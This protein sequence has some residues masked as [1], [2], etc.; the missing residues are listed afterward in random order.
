MTLH[1]LL[2]LLQDTPSLKATRSASHLPSTTACMTP[3]WRG[4]SSTPT[5]TP[6]TTFLQGRSLLMYHLEQ[7]TDVWKLTSR[8]TVLN[9]IKAVDFSLSLLQDVIAASAK[10][11]PT[12][13][14]KQ[15]GPLCCACTTLTW[16]TDIFPQS[17]TQPWFTHLTTPSSDTRGESSERDGWLTAEACSEA[18]W[19]LA[20]DKS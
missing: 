20:Q 19:D 17:T 9:L 4:W 18:S 16:W 11:S 8:Q 7:V 12:F 14:W 5:A 2:R 13:R 1:W 15:S 3:G 6:V 10:I